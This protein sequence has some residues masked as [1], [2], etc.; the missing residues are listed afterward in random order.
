MDIK[1]LL[2]KKD[3]MATIQSAGKNAAGK[4]LTQVLAKDQVKSMIGDQLEAQAVT[5]AGE[6]AMNFWMKYKKEL[7]IGGVVVGVVSVTGLTWLI[8]RAF[9]NK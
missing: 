4:A 3:L 1:S 5:T 8:Y 9:K 2:N 7:I 6:Q